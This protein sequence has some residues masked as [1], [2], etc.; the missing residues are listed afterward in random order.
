[1]KQTLWKTTITI[2]SDF[3]PVNLEI[4]DLAHEAMRGDAIC[5][6]QH[7]QRVIPF[8]GT[9]VPDSALDFFGF[10]DGDES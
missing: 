7:C 5:T 2:W 6:E 10:L 9:E 4:D 1:M 3:D 8:D